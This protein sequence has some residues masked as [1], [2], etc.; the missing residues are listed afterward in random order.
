MSCEAAAPGVSSVQQH[1]ARP[2]TV[3]SRPHFTL[4][5]SLIPDAGGIRLSFRAFPVI[6][7]TPELGRRAKI[8]ILT[9]ALVSSLAA[10]GRSSPP[11]GLARLHPCDSSEGPTDASCGNLEVFENRAAGTGRRIS[12][13]IVALPSLAPEAAADPLFF[14]AGGPGQA[15]AKMAADVREIFRPVLRQRDII[16]VD[17]RGTGKSHPLEC[18]STSNS[19]Q[20]LT[21]SDDQSLARLRGCLAGY[22][23]DVRLYTT[24]IAMDDLDD[25]R[26][27]LGYDRINLYGGSYGTRAALVYVRQHGQHVRSMVLDGVAPTDMRIPLFAAR[28]A[29]RALDKLLT[30]C[31]ADAAC[32]GTQPGLAARVRTLLQRLTDHPARVDVMHPRTGIRETVTIEARV[33][34]GILFSALYS[35]LTSSLVPTLIAR[36]E[37]NDFQSLLALAYVDAAGGDNLSVGM[38]LSVL[39]SEDATRVTPQDV[40]RES[41]G[42]VF[43]L[44]LLRG[45]LQACELWPHGAIDEVYFTPITSDVPALVLSGD[46]DPVTPPGWGESVAQHLKNARHI[47]VPA[48]GH[49]V[50]GTPCGQDLIRDFI[51][52]GT[53]G[54]LD[55]SCVS[56]VRR[57]PFFLTPSGAP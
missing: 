41:A 21:E 37:Q 14:L 11:R 49:G 33:V 32:R 45:Q 56:R 3:F 47:T 26:A 44:R 29:Q 22:D 25:V 15:A 42:T 39:C 27:H 28:D 48:T 4:S 51:E 12:L 40:G 53:A 34:A 18:R 57:P 19:L 36:A 2:G 35:P 24:P 16:L 43:G 17:Q 52:R 5:T 8:L 9:A 30:D 46:L 6:P 50:I 13:N 31:D 55:V 10:C 1:P 54:D 38:Q 23:A 20:E 7:P